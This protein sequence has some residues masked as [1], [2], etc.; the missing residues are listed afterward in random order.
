MSR[1][2]GGGGGGVLHMTRMAIVA[3]LSLLL[4]SALLL[5]TLCSFWETFDEVAV[6]IFKFIL[7]FNPTPPPPPAIMFASW[8]PKKNAAKQ[9]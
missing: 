4:F 3:P 6:S 8:P 7:F 9:F 1:G 5:R 2:G